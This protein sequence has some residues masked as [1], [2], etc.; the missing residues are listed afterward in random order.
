MLDIHPAHHAASTWRDFFIHVG[1][2]CVGL[3]IAIALEQA[4]E[5]FH[6]A[7]ERRE[8]LHAIHAECESNIE[9]LA[10]GITFYRQQID[11]E[12]NAASALR[13]A[14][15][16]RGTTTVTLPARLS[17]PVARA[18]SRAVLAVAKSSG[19]VAL[20]PENEA[21]V[22]DRVDRQAEQWLLHI[23]RTNAANLGL[24]NFEVKT[25]MAPVPGATLHLS[26]VQR[27]E[28]LDRLATSVGEA[29]GSVNWAASWEGA[30]Q[31]V[32][33]GVTTRTDM[34]AYMDRARAALKKQ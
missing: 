13:A 16:V 1:T 28:L 31:A 34:D 24:R 5:A 19:K 21:E 33:D 32:L 3:L 26:T 7:Q 29:R 11:W 8:L 30:S 6:R 15:V 18:P 22:L 2:I 10:T 14:P 23:D 17:V 12:T 4:V 27:D 20:L 9:T 25:G